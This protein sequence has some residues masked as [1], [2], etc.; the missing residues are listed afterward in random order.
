MPNLGNLKFGSFYEGK[1]TTWHFTFFVEQTGVYGDEKDPV[2][3]LT[4]DF[5]HVPVVSFCKETVTFPNSTFDTMN[6]DTLNTYFSYAG[7][8]DK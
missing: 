6:I 5:H 8:T 4:D 3:Y 1:N 7:T 2:G